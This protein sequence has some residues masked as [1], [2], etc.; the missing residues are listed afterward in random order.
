MTQNTVKESATGPNQVDLHL[1]VTAGAPVKPPPGVRDDTS[2][3]QPEN[4]LIGVE[5][6]AIETTEDEDTI[7]QEREADGDFSA[8]KENPV[9]LGGEAITTRGL[10]AGPGD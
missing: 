10:A 3:N 9:G 6:A 8:G 7:R 4:K 5:R 1:D 2:E